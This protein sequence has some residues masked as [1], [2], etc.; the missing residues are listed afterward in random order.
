MKE[1]IAALYGAGNKSLQIEKMLAAYR[2]DIKAKY[3]IENKIFS[4]IGTAVKGT[5]A[6]LDIISLYDLASKYKRGEIDC[7]AYST[8]YHLFDTREIEQRCL[9]AGIKDEDLYAVPIDILRK[10]SLETMD[11]DRILVRHDRLDQLYHLDIHIVDNCNLRC[12]GCSHFSSCVKEEKMQS[13]ADYTRNL[14]QLKKLVPNICRIA[15]LGGEPL[16]H[17]QLEDILRFT[18]EIYPF[19]AINVVTN[20]IL[21]SQMSRQ[22]IREMKRDRIQISLSLYP[23]MQSKLGDFLAFMKENEL[24]YT[25]FDCSKFEKRLFSSP[26]MDGKKMT[27]KCGHVL[28]M[29]ENKIGRCPLIMFTDYYNAAFGKTFPESDGIDIYQEESGLSLIRKLKEP[30]ELCSYCC[31]RDFYYEDWQI[32]GQQGPE[33]EDWIIPVHGREAKE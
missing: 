23:V 29:R 33:K 3:L 31:G 22:L 5:A 4:K 28:C 11:A 30:A 19:A 9:E 12:K 6:D 14:L 32:C 17:P 15:I 27:Q 10:G 1:K 24:H 26:V 20:G 18:R 2:K 8:E 21:L 16:L 13:L 7:V 25:I